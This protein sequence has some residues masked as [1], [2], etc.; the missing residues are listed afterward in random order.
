MNRWLLVLSCLA[1]SACLTSVNDV[2]LGNLDGGDVVADASSPAPDAGGL[3]AGLPPADGG[4]LLPLGCRAGTWCWQSPLPQG[5]GLN[6]VFTVSATEA[7][8]VGDL[9][10]TLRFQ[11]GT[12][13]AMEPITNA[14]LHSLTGSGPN[15]VWALGRRS[16]SINVT[17]YEVLH[18]DGTRWSL[19]PFGSNPVAVQLSATV[20]GEAWLV[21][22]AHTTTIPSQLLRWNGSGFVAAPA[23]PAGL[24][25]ES[26]CVRS[27]TEAWATVSDAQ[28]SWPIALY[29]FDGSAWRLV[30]RL[31]T[32]T[33]RFNSRVGCPADGVAVVQV[34][35]SGSSGDQFFTVRNGQGSFS[36]APTYGT[37]VI[38]GHGDVFSFD[39]SRAAKWTP[40]GWVDTFSLASNQSVYS[41]EFDLLGTV[42]WLAN[43][44]PQLSSW[45]GTGYTPQGRLEGALSVFVAPKGLNP[46]DPIAAF[47]SERWGART[48]TTW[49]FADNPMVPATSERFRV[50]AAVTEENGDAWLVGN[51]VFRFQAATRTLTPIATMMRGVFNAVEGIASTGIWAVGEEGRIWRSDGTNWFSLNTSPP[52]SVDG[53]ILNDLTFTAVDVRSANDVMVL[54]NDPA[55]GRFMS[56]FFH[57]NGVTWTTDALYGNTLTMFDRDAAGTVYVIDGSEVKKRAVGASTFTTLGT[58]AGSPM[59]L[60]VWGTDDVEVVAG[61]ALGVEFFRWDTDRQA[62]TAR[63]AKLNAHVNDVVV[64]APTPGG[65]ETFWALGSWGSVLRYEPIE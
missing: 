65:R 46:T 56:I 31:Q 57:W 49:T 25:V 6:S 58:L 35:D 41:V 15:D 13:T 55:G 34:L 23:L 28:N 12:W 47:G 37:T 63:G 53:V 45:T 59:R 22:A 62:F 60:K 29:Q 50:N 40:S 33:Q 44:T 27:A 17:E 21:T 42:G 38:T 32:T 20:P 3:D 26:V 7:W 36:A 18:F 8:A 64:G 9:G 52:N 2:V 4:T 51:Y 24:E 5:N 1:T 61:D 14:T 10:A 39:G 48:G 16:R 19:V 43:G 54:G 11:N 30:H